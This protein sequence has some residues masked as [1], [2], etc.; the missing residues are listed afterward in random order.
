MIPLAVLITLA[1]VAVL[2]VFGF[3]IAVAVGV[4]IIITGVMR[5]LST[6]G[7]KNDKKVRKMDPDGRNIILEESDYEVLES[8]DKHRN[9]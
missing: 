8:E 9:I 2:A 5:F 1:L 6:I 3:F 4:V 7:I